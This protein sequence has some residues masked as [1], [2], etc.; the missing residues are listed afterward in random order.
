MISKRISSILLA[1]VTANI[2][3]GGSALAKDVSGSESFDELNV[4]IDGVKS[5]PKPVTDAKKV[6]RNVKAADAKVEVKEN[7]DFTYPDVETNASQLIAVRRQLKVEPG[8]SFRVKVFLQNKGTIPWFSG[9][10]ICK[11]P[12]MYLGTDRERDHDSAFFQKGA[13]G[14]E[15]A[16]RILMDQL[17]VD[18]GQIASFTFWAKAGKYPDV[19]KEYFTPVLKDIQWLDGTIINVDVIIGD[20]SDNAGDVRQKISFSRKSGSVADLDLNAPKTLKVNL[21]E[22]KLYVYL[23]DTDVRDFRVSTGKPSTPTITGNYN[24]LIKQ[25]VR[26]GFEAPHYIMPKYMMF[27]ET[28]YGFHALP[29]LAHG[30]GDAFWTE[31]KDHI[32]IPVSHGCVRL[33]PDDAA[34]LFDFTDVGT[35]VEIGY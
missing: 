30:G 12:K 1:V 28:G 16:N 4:T 7:C 32:G 3:I 14:W 6:T 19:Y 35:K 34:W 27:Q 31:A 9:Q 22:Q 26:V 33:L 18:P 29:S 11:G 5:T 25:D 21:T 15:S 2:L 17:R 13:P 8:E 10:S 24:I 23:G 20:S